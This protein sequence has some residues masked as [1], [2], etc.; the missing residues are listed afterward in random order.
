MKGYDEANNIYEDCLRGDEREAVEFLHEIVGDLGSALELGVGSGRIALP[1]A[2]QGVTVKGIDISPATVA[3][4]REKPRGDSVAVTMGDFTDVAVKGHFQLIYVVW[5][6]FFNIASQEKQVC[7]FKNV[8]THLAQGGCFVI[9][10]F[11][12]SFLYKLSDNQYVRAE[13][14]EIDSVKLDVLQ[15][16]PAIQTLKENHV[17]LTKSGVSF[18]PVIQRYAWPCELDLMAN[19]AGLTLRDRFGDWKREPYSG[20]S[21]SHISVYCREAD[22]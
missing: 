14:I 15:H 22:L 2:I 18:S 21:D 10:A 13:G 17:S 6:T 20:N 1:L 9:E 11:V 8:A 4:M 16:D 7:C 19:M 12:P 3:Q 5:N